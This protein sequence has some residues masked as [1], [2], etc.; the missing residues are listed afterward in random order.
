LD[1]HQL[2]KCFRPRN[3]NPAAAEDSESRHHKVL[4]E[5]KI[6]G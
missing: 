5:K 3:Y 1:L 6:S 4:L 2:P